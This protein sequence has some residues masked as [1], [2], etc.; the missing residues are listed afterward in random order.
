MR[1]APSGGGGSLVWSVLGELPIWSAD[2]DRAFLAEVL[3]D[4]SLQLLG[5]WEVFSPVVAARARELGAAFP[6]EPAVCPRRRLE[7]RC[8]ADA[9]NCYA[10]G[11]SVEDVRWVLRDCDHPVSSLQIRSFTQQLGS[12]LFWRVDRVAH[13]ECRQTVLSLVAYHDLLKRLTRGGAPEEVVREFALSPSERWQLPERLTL[14]DYGL[15]HD[16]RAMAPQLV[17]GQITEAPATIPESFPDWSSYA[18]ETAERLYG[19]GWFE[20]LSQDGGPPSATSTNQA[21][22]ELFGDSQEP[23]VSPRSLRKKGH[24]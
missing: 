5:D 4:V 1:F 10:F 14:S 18:H 8:V 3:C 19:V 2:Q 13:P 11:L 21:Q 6:L 22:R 23:R 15:G 16:D 24:K 20:A 12:K 9:L 17:R 7:L